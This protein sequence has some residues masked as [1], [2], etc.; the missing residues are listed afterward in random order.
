MA[1]R[2]NLIK[3]SR[4]IHRYGFGYFSLVS[5]V[6]SVMVIIISITGIL[7]VHQHDLHFIQ[8]TYVN[9]SWLPGHYLERL[10]AIRKAQGEQVDPARA[11]VP[12]RWVVLDLHTGRFF[13]SWG[14]WFY[15]LLAAVFTILSITGLIIYLHMRTKLKQRRSTT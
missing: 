7:L 14:P 11:A 5:F 1:R 10:E 3:F 9:A 4:L 12:L 13:G 15:D 2:F 8:T 6:V